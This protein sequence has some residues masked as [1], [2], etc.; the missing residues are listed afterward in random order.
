MMA[1]SVQ[2]DVKQAFY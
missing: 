1:I 2:E